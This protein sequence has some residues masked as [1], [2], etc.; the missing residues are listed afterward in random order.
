MA[1]LFILCKDRE[2]RENSEKDRENREKD[3]ENREKDRENRRRKNRRIQRHGI[4]IKSD[5][6]VPLIL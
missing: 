3:R 2:N 5:Q 4:E 1:F 6:S